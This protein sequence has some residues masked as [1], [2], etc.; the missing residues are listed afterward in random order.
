MDSDASE[1][2]APA[3]TVERVVEWFETDAAGHHHHSSVVRWVESAEAELMRRHGLD[4][5]FSHSP[6]VHYEADFHSRLWFGERIAVSLRVTRLGRTSM[7][8]DFDIQGSEGPAA[9]GHV[10]VAHARPDERRASP[11]P[12]EVRAALGPEPAAFDA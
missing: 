10:V 8:M 2:A 5:L 9:S 3:I 7:R 4:H 11:W 6:R 12:D 1:Q